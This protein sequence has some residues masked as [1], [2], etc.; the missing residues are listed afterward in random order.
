MAKNGVWIIVVLAAV[1]VAS[2]PTSAQEPPRYTDRDAFDVYSALMPSPIGGKSVMVVNT[3]IKPERCTL[4]AAEM[5]AEMPDT[6]FREAVQDFH[7][8]NDEARILAGEFRSPVKADLVDR[9]ELDSYFRRGAD[10]GWKKFYKAHPKA[11]GT[12]AFSAVGFNDKR[13]V[14]VVYSE[15]ASC[16]ECGAGSLRFL[17]KKTEGWIEIKPGFAA[18]GWIS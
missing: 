13:T 12:V 6:D 15:V 18:C 7:R 8:K 9:K 17:E 2:Q 14:A 1:A 3:T 4:S 16:S 10:R 11:D 5:A